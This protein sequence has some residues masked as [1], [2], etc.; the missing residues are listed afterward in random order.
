VLTGGVFDGIDGI[1]GMDGLEDKKKSADFINDQITIA[2]SQGL[3]APALFS[4][5][6]LQSSPQRFPGADRHAH[7]GCHAGVA[8]CCGRPGTA[9]PPR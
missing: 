2:Q 1:L 7:R 6:R 4:V 8:S 9:N 3:G 5:V